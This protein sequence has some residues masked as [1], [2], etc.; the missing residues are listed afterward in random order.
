MIALVIAVQ[1]VQ[2]YSEQASVAPEGINAIIPE[3]LRSR[4]TVCNGFWRSG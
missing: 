4:T 3:C 2:L 1:E